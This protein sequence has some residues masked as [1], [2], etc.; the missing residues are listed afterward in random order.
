MG[1]NANPSAAVSKWKCSNQKFQIS[2]SGE[3]WPC[4]EYLVGKIHLQEM[5][6]WSES[7]GIS[8]QTPILRIKSCFWE[9]NSKIKK[10]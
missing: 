9:G 10:G 5:R 1:N 3:S 4:H 6:G 8:Y 7:E 2:D